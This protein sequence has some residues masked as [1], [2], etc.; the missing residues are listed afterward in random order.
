MDDA[1]AHGVT[2]L[3]AMAGR[4]LLFAVGGGEVVV[5][6]S[7]L[8]LLTGMA[9]AA[10]R[11]DMPFLP[12]DHPAREWVVQPSLHTGAGCGTVQSCACSAR[13]PSLYL[14]CTCVFIWLP[15]CNEEVTRR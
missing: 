11:A 12:L 3:P 14:E 15:R 1:A 9:P 13:T 6:Q 10:L 7:E 5:R 2:M 8:A 4:V